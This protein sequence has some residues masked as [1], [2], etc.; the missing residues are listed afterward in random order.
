MTESINNGENDK[1]NTGIK[2]IGFVVDL[3]I[4]RVLNTC[5]D[6]NVYKK[7][8]NVE[9]KLSYL[10][11]NNLINIDSDLFQG[12]ENKTKLVEKLLQF[13]KADPIHNLKILL[14]RIEESIID[15]DTKDQKKLNEYFLSSIADRNLNIKIQFDEESEDALPTG[16]KI[17]K[18]SEGDTDVKEITPDKD[19]DVSLTKDVLPFIIPLICI[20]SMNTEHRDILDMLNVIKSTPE[21][22]CVFQDQTFIWWNKPDIIKFVETIVEKYIKRNSCVY[23]IAIQFK[24]SLQSLIDNPKEL[25]E[26]IDSCLKPKKI[27]KDQFGE[28]FTP[29]YL[30]NEMLYNLD[31]S[32]IGEH[33][34]SIFTE[35]NLKWFDPASGM[36]NF[37]IAVYLKLMDGLKAQIPIDEDRKKHIL[38]NMLYMSELNKKNVFICRQIFDIGCQY[39]LNLYEGNSLELNTENVWGIKKFDVILGNPPYQRKVGPTKTETIW[40]KFIIKALIVLKS[41]GYLVYIHPSGWRNIDGKFKKIQKEILTRDLQYLEIHNEK[42]GMKTFSCSTRYDWYILK[43]ENVDNTKTIIKFQ[44][45]TTNIIN[46]IGLE[47]IPSGKYEKIMSMI[48]KNGEEVV[49]VIHDYS[50]Y[51]TRKSWMSRTKT[52]E[53]K[54]PCVYTVNSK[55]EITYYYSSKRHGHYEVPKFIWSNGS[56][57]SIGSYVDI[58]GDYGLTQFAY[59]IVDKTDNLYKIKEVFD[60][61]DF[62]N[63]MELCAVGQHTVNYKVISIFKKDFWKTF[64]REIEV[65]PTV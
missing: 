60:T 30:I 48:A 21:L 62:R 32:Y 63:L 47:F 15:M 42:D 19:V 39:A 22:L 45:G 31:K 64:T 20:L 23:N 25:L 27:E 12:K 41:P 57:S 26:L 38:E 46:V 16:K 65:K 51:E 28:V 11:E 3:N 56:I 54:Y 55:S 10:V 43:N 33:G 36:G 18:H 44:D 24:M 59:A 17:I 61:K 9:Q 50:L 5:L 1:I 34:R 6:Y 53:Y 8:L 37:P 35:L 52:E 7:D 40:D 58:N 29:M 14:K 2:K 13:W 49:D 4:S